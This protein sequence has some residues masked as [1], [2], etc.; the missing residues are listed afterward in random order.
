MEEPFAAIQP[1]Q[2]IAG[3]VELGKFHLV[4]R[5]VGVVVGIPCVVVPSAP[6]GVWR[7]AVNARCALRGLDVMNGILE[8]LVLLLLIGHH[9]FQCLDAHL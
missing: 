8:L 5:G 7:R 2:G 1:Q 6:S 9:C 4:H 3:V